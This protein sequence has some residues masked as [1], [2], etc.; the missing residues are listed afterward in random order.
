M[1]GRVSL[2]ICMQ[3]N[4]NDL[5]AE[6]EYFSIFAGAAFDTSWGVIQFPFGCSAAV[7]GPETPQKS[8]FEHHFLVGISVFT[9]PNKHTSSRD[10][11]SCQD[12]LHLSKQK[13]HVYIER[14]VL[15][16]TVTCCY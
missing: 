7:G 11:K 6:R 3:R 16:L 13:K 10:S 14:F 2:F 4:M 5:I 8:V 1:S 15:S 9:Y 12:L